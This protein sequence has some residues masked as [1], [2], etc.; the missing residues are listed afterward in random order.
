MDNR[1]VQMRVKG[2]IISLEETED[3]LDQ[4]EMDNKIEITETETIIADPIIVHELK[5]SQIQE[6]KTE[7]SK[8]PF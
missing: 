7:A 6:I 2:T 4:E 8:L 3:D 5:A 1:D